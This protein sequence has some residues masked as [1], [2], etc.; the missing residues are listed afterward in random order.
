MT[1]HSSSVSSAYL[2][3]WQLNDP[4]FSVSSL[5]RNTSKEK[6]GLFSS[7]PA[8][9]PYT[10]GHL[11]SLIAPIREEDDKRLSKEKLKVGGYGE[12]RPGRRVPP[13]VCCLGKA[14]EIGAG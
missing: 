7:T 4:M 14:L 6:R 9:F 8:T 3:C 12:V 2:E 5:G 13:Q 10:A 1:V 11:C